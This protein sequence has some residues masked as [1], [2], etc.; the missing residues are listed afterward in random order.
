MA[1]RDAFVI[2]GFPEIRKIRADNLE[3]WVFDFKHIKEYEHTV[4]EIKASEKRTSMADLT[5][6]NKWAED[7]LLEGKKVKGVFVVNQFRLNDL[8]KSAKERAIRAK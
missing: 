4:L 6:C 7:Y 1:V 5:Q 2:L 8:G 3:D